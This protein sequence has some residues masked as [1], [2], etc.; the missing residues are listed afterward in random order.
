[1]TSRHFGAVEVRLGEA[2]QRCVAHVDACAQLY[3]R[4]RK[5]DALLHAARP[6]TDVLPW[7]ETELRAYPDAFRSF[8]CSISAAGAGV[9]KNVRARKLRKTAAALEQSVDWLLEDIVGD[10]VRAPAF[11]KSVALAL[12]SSAQGSY[13]RAVQ[14]Q[15]LGDYQAA[16]ALSARAVDFLESTAG[17]S[18]ALHS[19]LRALR[20]LLPSLEPPAHLAT[21]EAVAEVVVA[22]SRKCESDIGVIVPGSEP[23]EASLTR[24]ERLVDDV[25]TSYAKG[26]PA[27][28]A[29]L[30]AS[31]YVRSYE[32][33]RPQLSEVNEPAARRLA[34]L[35]GV[36]LRRSI[37][38]GAPPH[39]VAELGAES[40]TLLDAVRSESR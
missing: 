26:V 21:P 11:R 3:G 30:A 34:E 27:L 10:E 31:L 1:M 32:A 22:I 35:L 14:A 8:T 20:I 23:I 36:E 16:Q 29:R 25:V 15:S 33:V 4:G 19:H 24:L 6:I 28:S 5:A 13:E 2:L 12:L 7:V 37:N 38:D 18:I 9:R 40:K 39:R 17:P